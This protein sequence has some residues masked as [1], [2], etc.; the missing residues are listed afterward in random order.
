MPN[1]TVNGTGVE[2]VED[3]TVF[4]NRIVR[5]AIKMLAKLSAPRKSAMRIACSAVAAGS[6]FANT[7][8]IAQAMVLPRSQQNLVR[9][10]ECLIEKQD[11]AGSTE[12]HDF[13]LMFPTNKAFYYEAED[14][15]VSSGG[16]QGYI[17][18]GLA[19]EDVTLRFVLFEALYRLRSV[20]NK[21]PSFGIALGALPTRPE[22]E[23]FPDEGNW[24][25][26]LYIARAA[27]CVVTQD[28]QKATTL[29]GA[30]IRTRE[31]RLAIEALDDAF[32]ACEIGAD[33]WYRKRVQFRGAIAERLIWAAT[34][35]ETASASAE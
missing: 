18:G 4:H 31:E 10:A 14:L 27:D 25:E 17:D 13:L 19:I 15:L 23:T 6:I 21:A 12:V 34:I 28:R 8:V 26:F 32:T 20:D 7:A 5:A 30:R 33:E 16:C 2:V 29:V 22:G 9:F 3:E 24:R 1:I 11:K 35:D